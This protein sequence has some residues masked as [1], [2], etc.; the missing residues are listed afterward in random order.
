MAG[1]PLEVIRIL[2]CSTCKQWKMETEFHFDR[3]QKRGRRSSC[4][5]CRKKQ[6]KAKPQFPREEYVDLVYFF[7]CRD[8]L[9]V[10]RW[11][12][13]PD[14]L[15]YSY[16]GKLPY[17]PQLIGTYWCESQEHAKIM[18][19]EFQTAL[20]HRHSHNEWFFLDPEVLP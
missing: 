7:R 14:Q 17:P 8:M 12:G 6:A 19:H 1:H 5:E 16:A 15:L 20:K 2:E 11:S 4:K 18:E 10:G 13:H 9:K 3:V